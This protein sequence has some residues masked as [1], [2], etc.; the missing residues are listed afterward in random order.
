MGFFFKILFYPSSE[1]DDENI[2]EVKIKHCSDLMFEIV[3]F[4]FSIYFSTLSLSA[5]LNTILEV[6]VGSRFLRLSAKG[7]DFIGE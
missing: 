6:P 1:K 5:A 2:F 4:F 3:S 7:P